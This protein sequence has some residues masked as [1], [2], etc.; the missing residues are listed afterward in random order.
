[1][2]EFKEIDRENFWEVVD[3]KVTKEQ[4]YFVASNAISIAQSKVQPECIP[5]AVYYDET[6]IGFVMYCLDAKDNEYWIYRMMIEQKFQGKGYG[7]K[8]LEKLI[9]MIK[10]KDVS[11]HKIY[12]D[13]VINNKVAIS[14]YKKLG[15][16]FDGRI[17]ENEHVMV[18]EY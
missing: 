16:E 17:I 6:L 12:L 18:L 10:E 13:V 8:T 3:L 2:I 7:Y 4:N 9:Q 15:F 14:L 5:Y 11:K 1:M